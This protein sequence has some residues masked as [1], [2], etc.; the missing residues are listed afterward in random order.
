MI[1]TVD[2]LSVH[3]FLAGL[4]RPWLERL[5]SHGHPLVRRTGQRIFHEGMPAERFWLIRSGR[6][7]L[8]ITDPRRGDI[9]IEH[10]GA[11]SVLGWSWLFPPYRWHFGA[12]AAEQTY[13]VEFDAAGVRRMIADDA[14]LG[15]ELTT[16]FLAVMADRLQATRLRLAELYA[17]NPAG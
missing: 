16:R 12:V 6:V 15:R 13:T 4:P 11:G 1:R 9:V 17:L 8:D 5:S 14:E 10:I 2:L 3:P 7:A